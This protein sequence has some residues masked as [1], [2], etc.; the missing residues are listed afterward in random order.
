MYAVI[1]M[2]FVSRTRATFRKAEFGFLGVV[3]NT[4]THTPRLK[5]EPES[6]GRFLMEL[7]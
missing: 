2:P 5:G 1:S 7:K 6:T 3:V 4:F